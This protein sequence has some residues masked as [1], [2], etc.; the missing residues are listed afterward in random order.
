VTGGGLLAG[1]DNPEARNMLA[2]LGSRLRRQYGTIG[3]STMTE[4][5]TWRVMYDSAD[6]AA[7]PDS[8]PMVAG[9]VRPSRYAIAWEG[10]NGFRRFPGRPHV[11][12]SVAGAEPDGQLASVADY[13]KGAFVP[14]QARG[15]VRERNA[16]HP[17]SATNYV[18]WLGTD[19]RGLR[20]LTQILE[21]C[22]GLEY[23]L[24]LA[25]WIEEPPN[26]DQVAMV[27][28]FIAPYEGVRL[29]AWQ[30]STTLGYDI[31]SVIDP[32]WHSK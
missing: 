7:I 1:Q 19:S 32:R 15:F 12:I 3:D 23:W 21:A 14:G 22:K 31:S 18:S 28:R 9:Y 2:G 27:E 24:W 30:H 4:P 20:M 10:M 16:L 25:W 13:E 5:D 11:H 29:A 26:A 17:G 6:P 8:A